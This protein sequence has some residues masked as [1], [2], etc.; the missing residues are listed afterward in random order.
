VTECRRL[1]SVSSKRAGRMMQYAHE[2]GVLDIQGAS[3]HKEYRLTSEAEHYLD[4]L[5]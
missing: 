4:E 2:F 5:L 3:N 1:I